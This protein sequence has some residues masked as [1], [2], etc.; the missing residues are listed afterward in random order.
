MFQVITRATF[1]LYLLFYTI[2]AQPTTEEPP[3]NWYRALTSYLA[4]KQGVFQWWVENVSIEHLGL[5]ASRDME[6]RAV[7]WSM[8]SRNYIVDDVRS[9]NIRR[10]D[11][12]RFSFSCIFT[13]WR[14][15]VVNLFHG[16]SL[17]FY[18][19]CPREGIPPYQQL[20][21]RMVDGEVVCDLLVTDSV[22]LRRP[23]L[24]NAESDREGKRIVSVSLTEKSNA[25]N[26]AARAA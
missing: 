9:V 10:I 3:I 21:G 22:W 4:C 11:D 26:G 19:I 16:S 6:T 5:P 15:T 18:M 25:G 13:T 2:L 1:S 8:V 12:T 24:T 7:V 20:H 14:A 17:R 23:A